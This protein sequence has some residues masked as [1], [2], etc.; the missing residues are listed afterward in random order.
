MIRPGASLYLPT[1]NTLWRIN[2]RHD[3]RPHLRNWRGFNDNGR[4]AGGAA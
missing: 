2:E 3:L 1:V 4:I